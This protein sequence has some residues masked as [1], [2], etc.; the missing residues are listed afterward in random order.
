MWNKWKNGPLYHTWYIKTQQYSFFIFGQ[1]SGKLNIFRIPYISSNV[2]IISEKY[3]KGPTTFIWTN[4]QC[5]HL[6]SYDNSYSLEDC[7]FACEENE[8]CTA[9][10]FHNAGGCTS[11][12][13]TLRKCPLP[14]PPPSWDLNGWNGYY[15]S[16]GKELEY[17]IIKRPEQIY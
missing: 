16:L 4:S 13:C 6:N 3:W 8:N 15:Q 11:P 7:K 5:N 14:A 9:I 10:T 17:L 2:N 1:K 12:C